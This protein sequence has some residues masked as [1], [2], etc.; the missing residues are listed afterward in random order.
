MPGSAC[1]KH[2]VLRNPTS[3]VSCDASVTEDA[4]LRFDALFSV[5][6]LLEQGAK[7]H[8]EDLRAGIEHLIDPVESEPFPQAVGSLTGSAWGYDP[9]TP[10]C[11]H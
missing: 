2:S 7:A 5:Q 1:N 11:G 6:L 9:I 10:S 3:S 4:V 8:S